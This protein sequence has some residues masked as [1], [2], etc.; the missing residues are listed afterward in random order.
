MPAEF[1]HKPPGGPERAPHPCDH[2][3]GIP[4]PVERSVA[5]HGVEFADERQILPVHDAGIQTQF[6]RCLNLSRAAVH[7]YDIA[8][9]CCELRRKRSVTA[10][11]VENAFPGA[12]RKQLDHRCA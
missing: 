5:E 12:G 10:A 9:H 3:F 2:S 1:S 8:S 7:A 6:S 11:K 4:H